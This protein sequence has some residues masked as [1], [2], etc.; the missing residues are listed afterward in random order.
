MGWVLTSEGGL[1][2]V[3][4]TRGRTQTGIAQRPASSPPLFSSRRVT[5][6]TAVVAVGLVAWL[7][8]AWLGR[9]QVK[10]VAADQLLTCRGTEVVVEEAIG[11]SEV[12][13]PYALVS[14]QMRC[15]VHW[16]RPHPKVNIRRNAIPGTSPRTRVQ[17]C[18]NDRE[19]AVGR[20]R[21][22]DS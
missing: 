21:G 16:L 7:G 10:V 6:I 8:A 2:S 18:R 17:R 11:D 3:P 12:R 14:G 9:S 20:S 22:G 1:S 15:R 5:V 4:V 19:K 13:I